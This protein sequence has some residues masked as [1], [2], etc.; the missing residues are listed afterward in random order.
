MKVLRGLFLASCLMIVP[1]IMAQDKSPKGYDLGSCMSDSFAAAHVAVVEKGLSI[2]W[3][4][5]AP[6][7][8][9]KQDHPVVY[10]FQSSNKGTSRY[11]Y[12]NAKKQ[13]L[14]LIL[15][16]E[17]N[18]GLFQVDGED[19]AVILIMPDD[20]ASKLADNALKEFQACVDLVNGVSVPD[21]AST[22]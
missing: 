14:E 10:E 11:V 12:V 22:N 13:K 9:V 15:N 21:R 1:F 18:L 5:D 7:S 17:K 19:Q 3:I 6:G 2:D 16:F 4:S 8:V 20:D